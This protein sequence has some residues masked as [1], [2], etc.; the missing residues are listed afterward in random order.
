MIIARLLEE[1]GTGDRDKNRLPR[2]TLYFCLLHVY[3]Y[4]GAHTP[5]NTCTHTK[6]EQPE[7]V[8]K[9]SRTNAHTQTHSH[10]AHTHTHV[11]SQTHNTSPEWS[12]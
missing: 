10:T 2:H 12:M 11:H 4:K 7:F 9:P 6:M 8:P 3:A 1:S 5:T